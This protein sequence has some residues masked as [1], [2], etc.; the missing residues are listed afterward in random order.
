MTIESALAMAVR[1]TDETPALRASTVAVMGVIVER[2][3]QIVALCIQMAEAAERAA[4]LAEAERD[5]M[6]TSNLCGR[7]TALRSIAAELY[8]S[9]STR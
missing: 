8:V 3:A 6:A 4:R 2:D 9:R 7:A 5:D 1:V